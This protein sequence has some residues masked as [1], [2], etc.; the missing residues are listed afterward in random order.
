MLKLRSFIGQKKKSSS[1]VAGVG[2]KG[3]KYSAKI[4]GKH[5]A[6]YR[7][8]RDMLQRCY[9][10]EGSSR[11]KSYKSCTVSENFKSFEYFYEWCQAQVG[12]G[13]KDEKGKSWH[14]DKDL[15][16]KGNKVYSEDT[17]VFIPNKINCLFVN[18]GRVKGKFMA[19]VSFDDRANKF[20]SQCSNGNGKPEKLGTFKTEIEAFQAYKVFKEARV[21]RVTEEFKGR[22]DN[23]AYEALLSWEVVEN[24]QTV[25]GE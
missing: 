16:V 10:G 20:I 17:C 25:I 8:W 7:A 11:N 24:T 14:L 9:N 4:D 15:L 6:E 3:T 12:F 5:T 21:K 13:I 1:L 2:F 18:C 23:R 22:I 19:G